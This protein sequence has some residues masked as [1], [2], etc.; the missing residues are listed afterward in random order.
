MLPDLVLNVLDLEAVVVRIVKHANTIHTKIA[1]TKIARTVQVQHI[2]QSSLRFRCLLLL[3]L[4]LT[5]VITHGILW[6]R[7]LGALS[8]PSSEV[9]KLIDLS[10]EFS[11]TANNSPESEGTKAWLP[12][13]KAIVTSCLKDT[14]D[15]IPKVFLR[16]V[17]SEPIR[18]FRVE[19]IILNGHLTSIGTFSK[20]YR[21]YSEERGRQELYIA[22]EFFKVPDVNDLGLNYRNWIISHELG[23][24][25]DTDHRLDDSL[26]WRTIAREISER[27]NQSLKLK[28]ISDKD[29]WKRPGYDVCIS[30]GVPTPI[31][32]QNARELFAEYVAARCVKPPHFTEPLAVRTFLDKSIFSPF[33]NPATVVFPK[34]NENKSEFETDQSRSKRSAKCESYR[35]LSVS[36]FNRACTL[37][38]INANADA[39]VLFRKSLQADPHNV[40]TIEALWETLNKMCASSS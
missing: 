36:S 17:I 1:S 3:A 29:R 23:H 7:P 10:T 15:K 22:D 25:A 13:E 2:K 24:L 12:A 16:A 26:E 19:R 35:D 9:G 30:E 4:G 37:L 20:S 27:T 6:T 11:D 31:A 32:L 5:T 39:V 14:I 8:A 38:L 34:Q 40:R 21:V 33:L 18:I 28:G